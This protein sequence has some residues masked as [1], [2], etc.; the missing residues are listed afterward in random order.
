MS[1]LY[2]SSMSATPAKSDNRN[3]NFFLLLILTNIIIII[4]YVS[5]VLYIE[6][7]LKQVNSVKF[8]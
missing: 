4:I 3:L 7:I 8:T 2:H 1:K 5:A 6:P